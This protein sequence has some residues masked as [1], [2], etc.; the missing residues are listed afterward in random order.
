MRSSSFYTKI[1]TLD[2]CQVP[3]DDITKTYFERKPCTTSL[4]FFNIELKYKIITILLF[5]CYVILRFIWMSVRCFQNVCYIKFDQEFYIGKCH[6]RICYTI[7]YNCSGGWHVSI[8]WRCRVI[9]HNIVR[10][11][12]LSIT[13]ILKPNPR[14]LFL[15]MLVRAIVHLLLG[16]YYFCE[17]RPK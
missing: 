15:Q 2:L 9:F 1:Q 13:E 8:L 6:I 12:E 7:L 14:F 4:W 11:L 16:F 10:Y 3:S 17:N 5:Y